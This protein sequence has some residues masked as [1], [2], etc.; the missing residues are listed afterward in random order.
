MRKTREIHEEFFKQT[1][2]LQ[3]VNVISKGLKFVPT[4]VT[5]TN[6]IRR[7]L[8]LDF[9]HFARRMRLKDTM[10]FVNC[11]TVTKR[12]LTCSLIKL[13]TS[14]TIKFTAEISE[15]E[16][17]YYYHSST[18]VLPVVPREDPRTMSLVSASQLPSSSLQ[19]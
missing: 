10:D 13:T 16:T 3:P 6:Y 11:G 17:S 2:W 7:Q 18:R 9:E 12:K 19:Q 5:D 4:P 8:L 14:T 15:N 1:T